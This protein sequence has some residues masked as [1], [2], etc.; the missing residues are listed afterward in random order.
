ML[1]QQDTYVMRSLLALGGKPFISL[2]LSSLAVAADL[3][4]GQ[5]A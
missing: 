1:V 3:Q 2:A 4:S 5:E